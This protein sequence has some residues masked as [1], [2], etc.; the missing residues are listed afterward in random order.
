LTQKPSLLAFLR[1]IGALQ[2]IVIGVPIGAAVFRINNAFLA[3]PL[4]KENSFIAPAVCIGAVMATLLL[5]LVRNA[6][7]AKIISVAS[8]VCFLGSILLYF[9]LLGLYVRP[10]YVYSQNRVI[11]VSV[12]GERTQFA[13]EFFSGKSDV[14]M[15]QARGIGE[16]EILK[17][18]TPSSVESNR[19]QLLIVYMLILSSANLC[20]GALAMVSLL[21]N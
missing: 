6:S 14:E 19:F 17:L 18:W 9:H 1:R 5:W 4:G 13:N 21:E 15:L 3:P 11:N 12:G 8:L 10:V 20:I 16:D 2:S 7:K